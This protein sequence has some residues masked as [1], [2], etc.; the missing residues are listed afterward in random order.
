MKSKCNIFSRI[1]LLAADRISSTIC[2]P[3]IT[4]LYYMLKPPLP[5]LPTAC[6]PDCWQLTGTI[7]CKIWPKVTYGLHIFIDTYIYSVSACVCVSVRYMYINNKTQL[8]LQILYAGDAWD[9]A[10]FE[11]V[12]SKDKRPRSLCLSLCVWGEVGS[13]VC[14]SWNCNWSLWH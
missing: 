13:L 5:P 9:A 12:P 4:Y 3:Y 7:N 10:S 14:R 6:L 2:M 11:I 1:N 8:Q